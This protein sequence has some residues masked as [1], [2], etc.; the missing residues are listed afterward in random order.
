MPVIHIHSKAEFDAALKK[1]SFKATVVDFTA[2]WC[3]YQF[4]DLNFSFI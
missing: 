2:T 1:T 4:F 3:N